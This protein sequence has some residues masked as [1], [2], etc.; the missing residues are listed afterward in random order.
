MAVEINANW[1][2][3]IDGVN[4]GA[5]QDAVENHK[6]RA[7]ELRRAFQAAVAARAAENLAERD[8]ITA[9]M[10][11]KLDA[12]VAELA[13]KTAEAG[14]I[15]DQ[16]A[17]LNATIN[18]QATTIAE[19]QT[20]LADANTRIADLQDKAAQSQTLIDALGGTEL[21]Q[22]LAAEKRLA[23]IAA[24]RQ[25]LSEAA[26]KLAEEERALSG[27]VAVEAVSAVN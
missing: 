3:V 15:S 10:Q 20:R 17:A 14:G 11:A 21:G 24:E 18:A 25:R 8:K 12:K 26:D 23:A 7:A 16:C 4:A 22:K 2:A 13:E 1:E 6:P 9:S 27:Q 5:Y 19:L